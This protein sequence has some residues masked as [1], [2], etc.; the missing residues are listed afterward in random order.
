MGLASSRGRAR[1]A[2]G[3]Q[4]DQKLPEPRPGREADQPEENL[5]RPTE[6]KK[7]PMGLPRN[8]A[9]AEVEPQRSDE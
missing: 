1:H 7:D 5:V 2:R 4:G 8:A 6:Q 9:R 3:R